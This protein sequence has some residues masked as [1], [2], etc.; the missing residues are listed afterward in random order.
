MA[1]R[2]T[3]EHIGKEE[4]SGVRG[5]GSRRRRL[6]TGAKTERRKVDEEAGKTEAYRRRCA[7]WRSPRATYCSWRE[8]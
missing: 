3:I 7:P 4:K 6:L 2:R 1:G 5:G 8:F